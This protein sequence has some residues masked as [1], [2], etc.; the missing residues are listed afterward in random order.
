MHFYFLAVFFVLV[1]VSPMPMSRC[2]IK[3]QGSVL[4]S[5]CYRASS[6]PSMNAWFRLWRLQGPMRPCRIELVGQLRFRPSGWK[7]YQ[8]RP[9]HTLRA[10]NFKPCVDSPVINFATS[11]AI[12]A[13]G[14]FN[15]ANNC[16]IDLF[17]S[18]IYLGADIFSS[19]FSSL[20]REP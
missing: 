7:S 18:L 4:A 11:F 19:I 1:F 2:G 12:H 8:F 15:V 10:T 20:I 5:S 17:G 9:L 3:L 6:T 14:G 13:V 16:A